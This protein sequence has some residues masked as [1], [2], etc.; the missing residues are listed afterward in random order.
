MLKPKKKIKLSSK[1]LKKDELL[2][3]VEQVSAWYYENQRNVT[4][5]AIA[6]V[7]V[8]AATVFYFYNANSENERASGELG[9]VY[10]LYDQQQFEQAIEG[11]A[12][13]N[14][15]GLKTIADKYSGTDAGEIAELY[16]ANAYFA[17]GKFDEAH[18]HYDDC[19]VSDSRLQAAVQ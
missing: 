13:R 19:S 3:F 18:K 10:S 1:E 7:I 17:L 8:V 12:E 14:I 5:V 16:L 15:P 2:T 4:T 11:V 9:K 6:V